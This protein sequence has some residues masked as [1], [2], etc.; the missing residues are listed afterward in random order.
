MIPYIIE[1]KRELAVAARDRN[2]LEPAGF[3]PHTPAFGEKA[4]Q[5]ARAIA[6]F[7]RLSLADRLCEVAMRER[8]VT[9]APP[10]S[11]SGPEV[12]AYL[13]AA[14]VPLTLPAAAKAWCAAFV[15]WCLKRAQYAGP[16]PTGP[17]SVPSW[18]SWAR[19]HGLWVPASRLHA[20]DLACFE[21][22]GDPTPEHIGIVTACLDARTVR[23]V[24]GN[25][26]PDDVGS[27][28]NGGGVYA[29]TRSHAVIR[30]AVRLA[31]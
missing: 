30:G 29:R 25:T 4:A 8:G 27:Q 17:A 28:A 6:R 19:A 31:P 7:D 21:F 1:V 18:G 15:T 10:G 14:G 5:L 3:D 13:R 26:S 20:G 2:L 11:N 9:E 12:D 24:E 23:T 22:D 16:W